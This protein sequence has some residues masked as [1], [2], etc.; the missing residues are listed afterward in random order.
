MIKSLQTTIIGFYIIDK[1]FKDISN[2]ARHK[3]VPGLLL[4]FTVVDSA[5]V[6]MGYCLLFRHHQP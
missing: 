6:G 3:V 1:N 4:F 5:Q 2:K